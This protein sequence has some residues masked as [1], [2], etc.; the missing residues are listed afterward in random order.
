MVKVYIHIYICIALI[1]RFEIIPFNPLINPL[2]KSD[3]KPGVLDLVGKW[4]SYSCYLQ[5]HL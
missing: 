3:N 4:V 1:R 5:Y 2:D